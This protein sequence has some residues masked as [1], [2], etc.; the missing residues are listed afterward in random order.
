LKG[1]CSFMKNLLQIQCHIWE[2]WQI[3]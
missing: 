2:I 1:Q 3:N